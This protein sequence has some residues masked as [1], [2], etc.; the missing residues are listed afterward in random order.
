MLAEKYDRIDN[1]KGYWTVFTA[2][3]KGCGLCKEKCPVQ[4]ISW[5]EML[6]VYGTPAVV[7]DMEKCIV[8]GICQNVCPDCAIVVEKK[9]KK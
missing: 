2:L 6:G 7:A 5:S 1:E 4:C 8:C 3:C 9:P